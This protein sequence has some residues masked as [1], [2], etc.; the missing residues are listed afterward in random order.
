MEK[1]NVNKWIDEAK[2]NR[3]HLLM[4]FLCIC[5]VTFDGYDLVIYG[6]AVPL[7]LKEFGISPALAGVIGSYALFGA[8]FGA[9]LF[10]WLADKIGRKVAIIICSAVFSAATGLTGLANGPDAFAIGR[11]LAGVGIGGAMPN[12]VA[13]VSEY[14]PS[15]NRSLVVAVIFSGMQIGGIAAAGLSMWLFPIVG[16]R[17][18][19]YIGA[20]PLLLI[21][22]FIKSLP[23]SP[24]KLIDSNRIDEVKAILR[25]LR[26]GE[27][28]SDTAKLEIFRTVSKGS[29]RDVFAEGRGMS[30]VFIWIVYFMNM[31]MIFGLG[32][33]LPKL[34]MDA[35]FGLG[36][37]LWF[38]L[39]LQFAAFFGSQLAG[40]LA[41]RFGSKVTMV[42]AYIIAFLAIVLMA[43]MKNFYLLSVLVALAGSGYYAGQNVAHGYVS[44]YYPQAIRSTGMG[45]AFGVGRL[46]AILG[47]AIAGVI[48][49]LKLPL[50]INFISLAVPGLIAAVV[51]LF[52]RDKRQV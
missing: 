46:G 48:M 44:L 32:I 14:A 40:F 26:P 39:V 50:T 7:L 1:V 25:K 10:G 19:F 12:I 8:A 27:V 38:L 15:R 21:P 17:P 42:G 2:I 22:L 9:L 29:V 18:I 3:F 16:W 11:F 45:L 24:I 51:I 23:E 28:F 41:D 4:F 6:A 30:T 47:P 52:V 43:Y 35:G 31:Y 34:M 20:L 33:W 37:G 5:I 13:L 49:S 36:S